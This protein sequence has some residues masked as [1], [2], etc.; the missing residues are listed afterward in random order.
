MRSNPL[1]YISPN[2][3]SLTPN[4]NGSPNDIAVYIQRDTKIKVYVPIN[5][6]LGYVDS[7]IQEWELSGK[8]RR[9]NTNNGEYTG[10]F[11]IFARINRNPQTNGY[12]AYLVF[13]KQAYYNGE[14]LDTHSS[15][16][17]EPPGLTE[18]YYLGEK[19][20]EINTSYWYVRLGEVSAIDPETNQRTITLDTG[21]L[22][23]EQYNNNWQVI[24]EEQPLRVEITNSKGSPTPQLSV[25]ETIDIEAKL[26]KG[27]DKDMSASVD[28]WTIERDTGDSTADQDWNATDRSGLG[29][30]NATGQMTLSNAYGVAGDFNAATSATFTIKAWGN[31]LTPVPDTE[32]SSENDTSELSLVCLATGS[33]TI[34]AQDV[35]YSS[36][37][38]LDT[39]G[40]TP[41]VINE[42]NVDDSFTIGGKRAKARSFYNPNPTQDNPSAFTPALVLDQK[43]G[44]MSAA[45]GKFHIGEDGRVDIQADSVDLRPDTQEGIAPLTLHSSDNTRR[46]VMTSTIPADGASYSEWFG[47]AA[48]ITVTYNGVTYEGDVLSL[49]VRMKNDNG[50][51]GRM[52]ILDV[53][54]AANDD[55]VANNVSVMDAHGLNLFYG[56]NGFGILQT[57]AQLGLKIALNQA[58][59]PYLKSNIGIVEQGVMPYGGLK[60]TNI[61]DLPSGGIYVDENGFLKVKE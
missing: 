20:I 43:T 50:A 10:A 53:T 54:A 27:F 9:L 23:T 21:I 6:D 46:L 30:F 41:T 38:T 25:G 59:Y 57:D 2:D 34:Y 31:D 58:G 7:K 39:G 15:V 19:Q 18:C 1:Y 60:R 49:G 11:T 12:K 16:T 52:V 55:L 28:H 22:G 5:N 8:N 17:N 29:G 36:F 13:S 51:Y 61:S 35:I 37:G 4:A 56:P 47:F 3:I 33:I 44:A 45:N 14:W 48:P 40:A 26:V 42:N 32:D 24:E